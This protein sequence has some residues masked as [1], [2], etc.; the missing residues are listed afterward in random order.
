MDTGFTGGVERDDGLFLYYL[1]ILLVTLSMYY[2]CN[3]KM[4]NKKLQRRNVKELT[5]SHLWAAKGEEQSCF[6]TPRNSQGT[7][8]LGSFPLHQT[9][10]LTLASTGQMNT[11]F[12]WMILRLWEPMLINLFST[13]S[14]AKADHELH[15]LLRKGSFH[16]N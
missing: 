11:R 2:F 10:F 7:S 5:N 6:G 1:G 8:I 15:Y 3:Y 9:L 13:K 14:H 16:Y 4:A 12:T